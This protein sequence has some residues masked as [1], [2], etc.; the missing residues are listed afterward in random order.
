V[1][2]LAAFDGLVE[3]GKVR[4]VAISNYS[5]ARVREWLELTK[6]NGF[7]PPIALQPLLMLSLQRKGWPHRNWT[8][9]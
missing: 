4:H 2:S 8:Q 9:S 7:A 1:E 5:P 3:A 6:E